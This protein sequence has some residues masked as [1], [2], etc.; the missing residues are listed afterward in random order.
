MH[1]HIA[2]FHLNLTNVLQLAG[3]FLHEGTFL[4]GTVWFARVHFVDK[5]ADTKLQARSPNT[6]LLFL[7]HMLTLLPHVWHPSERSTWNTA[8][9]LA[10]SSQFL[11]PSLDRMRPSD[12]RDD[13]PIYPHGSPGVVYNTVRAMLVVQGGGKNVGKG[14]GQEARVVRESGVG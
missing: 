3:H 9:V 10:I 11:F 7:I 5:M 12:K 6:A 2:F 4:R 14:G 1:F 8:E 13:G